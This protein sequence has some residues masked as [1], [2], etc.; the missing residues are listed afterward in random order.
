MDLEELKQ[1]ADAAAA[2]LG[3][4]GPRRLGA[5]GPSVLDLARGKGFKVIVASRGNAALSL[6]RE[7]LPTAITL[8][9]FLPDMLGWTVLNH[10]KQD[11]STRHIPVQMLTLDEDRHHGLTRGAFSFVP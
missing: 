7:F 9:I 3:N 1:K 5:T 4:T 10:L 6:A 8:D 11:P 2:K